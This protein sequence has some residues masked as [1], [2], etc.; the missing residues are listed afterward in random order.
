ML[1]GWFISELWDFRRPAD[2]FQFSGALLSESTYP[3]LQDACSTFH[4]PPK[5]E[6]HPMQGL[7]MAPTLPYLFSKNKSSFP[8]SPLNQSLPLLTSQNRVT[9]PTLN[10]SLARGRISVVDSEQCFLNLS[11]HQS[12]L[13]NWW[14][15]RFLATTPKGSDSVSLRVDW[16]FCIFAKLLH[17]MLMMLV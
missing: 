5:M 14:K 15:N 9:C 8:R 4:P 11:G 10:Q 12:G 3:W 1:P 17:V 16:G 13:G 6:Q 7:G 2:S